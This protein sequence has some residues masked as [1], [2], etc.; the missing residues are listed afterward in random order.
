L[1]NLCSSLGGVAD[2]RSQAIAVPVE[3]GASARADADSALLSLAHHI[4]SSLK[5]ARGARFF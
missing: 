1:L 5:W 2:I 3:G 4:S